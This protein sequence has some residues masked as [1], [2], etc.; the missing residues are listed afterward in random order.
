MVFVEGSVVHVRLQL[1]LKSWPC[2]TGSVAQGGLRES[3]SPEMSAT[4]RPCHRPA[5]A[6]ANGEFALRH[7]L[8]VSSTFNIASRDGAIDSNTLPHGFAEV[9]T[10]LGFG[11]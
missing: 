2:P 6:Q 1:S 3:A 9:N 5:A 11:V 7:S 8:V 10:Y 4:G